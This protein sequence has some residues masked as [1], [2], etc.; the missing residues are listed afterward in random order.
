MFF[1]DRKSPGVIVQRETVNSSYYI[2][3]MTL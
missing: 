3:E 1:D 2:F